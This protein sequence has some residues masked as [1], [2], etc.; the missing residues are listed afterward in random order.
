[1]ASDWSL[2][3]NGLRDLGV[4]IAFI[5]GFILLYNFT[6]QRPVLKYTFDCSHKYTEKFNHSIVNLNLRIDNVG[7][8]GTTMRDFYFNKI[9]PEKYMKN[10]HTLKGARLPIQH[11]A[12][13]NSSREH[14]DVQFDNVL[15]KE[16]EIEVE[17]ELIHTHGKK[18]LSA[19]SKLTDWDNSHMV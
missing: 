10:L 11:I 5:S 6:R 8:R 3:L 1:M 4:V 13:H 9:Y 2:L 17:I 16:K 18:N 19:V 12:P 14:V 15:M 7:E